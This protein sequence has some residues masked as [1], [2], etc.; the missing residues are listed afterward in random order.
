MQYLLLLNGNNSHANSL[1]VT[2]YVYCL[3]EIVKS[4]L[5]LRLMAFENI[6]SYREEG[7]GWWRKVL[8]ACQ[9]FCCWANRLVLTLLEQL[10]YPTVTRRLCGRNSSRFFGHLRRFARS[11]FKN[12][13][14][15]F[16]PFC[17]F[18]NHSRKAGLIFVFWWNMMSEFCQS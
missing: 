18:C 11:S 17:L 13:S 4:S 3:S 5:K 7:T 2:L 10:N 14:V 6:W 12:A 8:N 15:V 16:H 1:S 9:W